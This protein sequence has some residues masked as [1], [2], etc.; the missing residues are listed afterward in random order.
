MLSVLLR[1]GW[2]RGSGLHHRA[3]SSDVL[4]S[5]THEFKDG[6]VEGGGDAGGLAYS[7]PILTYT[8]DDSV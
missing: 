1:H 5:E 7:A 8:C 4:I 6:D 3:Q 2:R